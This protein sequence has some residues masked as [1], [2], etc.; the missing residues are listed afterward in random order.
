M[1]EM[2]DP[3][4]VQMLRTQHLPSR[5]SKAGTAGFYSTQDADS[6]GEEGK[7]F[8]WTPEET[9]EMLGGRADVFMAAHSVTRRG[10]FEA[11]IPG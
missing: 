2:L 1:R 8:V 6:E 5:P 10:S 4:G 3:E 7:F 9:R 11:P